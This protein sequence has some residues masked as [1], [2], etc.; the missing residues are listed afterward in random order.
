MTGVSRLIFFILIIGICSC[1]T[2]RIR[3]FL[4]L[5]EN[6]IDRFQ[7][8]FVRSQMDSNYQLMERAYGRISNSDTV[9]AMEEIIY[10]SVNIEG[11]KV[12]YAIATS[13]TLKSKAPIGPKY[14]L[15]S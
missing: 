7:T 4:T 14:F 6:Q 2:I 10:K 15:S 12:F 5:R 1:S 9:I 3:P 8:F 11:H 13:D